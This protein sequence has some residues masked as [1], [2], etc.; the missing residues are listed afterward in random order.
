M[1][2]SALAHRL[3]NHHFRQQSSKYWA[4]TANEPFPSS[5]Q[6]ITGNCN[7][8]LGWPLHEPASSYKSWESGFS[9]FWNEVNSSTLPGHRRW[10]NWVQFISILIHAS[11]AWWNGERCTLGISWGSGTLQFVGNLSWFWGHGMG[12]LKKKITLIVV[13]LPFWGRQQRAGRGFFW[14]A[15]VTLFASTPVENPHLC[16]LA[17]SGSDV[18]VKS[19]A[20]KW[21]LYMI[22]QHILTYN[23]LVVQL[24]IAKNPYKSL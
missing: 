22:I 5:R 18:L 14:V 6:T 16:S 9:R 8:L 11:V 20:Y 12:S 19:L 3:E 17:W 15:L 7:Q 24:Y 13:R 2:C 21:L 23:K 4:T 1:F 10:I